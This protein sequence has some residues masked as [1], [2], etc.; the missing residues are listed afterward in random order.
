MASITTRAGKG[1]PL[2]NAELDANFSNLNNGKVENNF[3]AVV[4]ALGYTPYNATNP[5]NYLDV[6]GVRASLSVS[7][8]LTYNPTTGVF[9]VN[10]PVTSV[11]GKTGAVTLSTSDVSEGSN[12]YFTTA[13]ARTSISV[14]G[15]LTY[16]SS[17]GVL[18]VNVPVTSVFGRTG[19][20]TLTSGDVTGALGFT[21]YN[22]TNPA[23]YI[24]GITSSMVTTALGYTPPQPNGT[25]ASGTWGISISGNAATVTNGVYTTGTQTIGGNKTFSATTFFQDA[26]HYLALSSGNVI[27]NKD[28][29]DYWN[30]ARSTNVLTWIVGGTTRATF[31][32]NGDFTASGT[33]TANSDERLKKDWSP[34]ASD[35]VER[36][37]VIKSGTYTRIDTGD[38]QAGVSAQDVQMILG[39]VVISNDEG[40]LSVAYGN[41]A[42]VACVELAKRVVS[43]EQKLAITNENTA[44]VRAQ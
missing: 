28:S 15:D 30:F 1:S 5:S 9:G 25:G 20:V 40:I 43:L 16:N 19:A 27:Y 35:F 2:T 31:A 44:N 13:R 37:A 23:G 10:V 33:I 3:S 17:T 8:D 11:A 7:G 36:L 14:S 34:V 38:R 29:N 18:G 42:L 32:A 6:A 22:A 24:S 4:A 12:Q 26:N 21:P 39:E 41:A